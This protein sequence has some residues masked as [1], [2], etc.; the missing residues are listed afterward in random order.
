MATHSVPPKSL[1][2]VQNE[3]TKAISVT[4]RDTPTPTGTQVLVRV[5]YSGV[6]GSDMHLKLRHAPSLIPQPGINVFGHEGSGTI[7]ALGPNVDDLTWKVGDRVGVRWLQWVCKECEW[8][9]TGY[10]NLCPKR[11]VSGKDVNGSFAQYALADSTYL[12]RI[13]EGVSDEDAAPILC[14]GVT[15]YKA[16]KVADLRKG[17]WVACVGAG[18]GLGHLAIQ[19]AKAMGYRPLAVDARKRDICVKL[20]AEAYV[21]V[22]EEKDVVKAVQ[23]VTDGGPQGVIVTA[24]S[25]RAYQDAP[26]YL[27]RAGTMVCIGL[28]DEPTIIPV[29]PQDFIGRGIKLMGSSTGN[30]ED[31]EEALDFVAKGLVKPILTHKGFADI[32]QVIADMANAKLEG[33]VVVKI[34]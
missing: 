3:S 18:G 9:T 34:D 20:G 10:Q 16:I 14:A 6:C 22:A 4:E 30:I 32:N 24:S 21:D 8:C 12:V 7:A 28:P 19:Y 5:T 27:R 25:S 11:K 15:V 13:P 17:S 2:A 23:D 31:T 1:A 33:R 26:E 29:S